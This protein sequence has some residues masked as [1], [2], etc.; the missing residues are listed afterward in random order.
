MGGVGVM[1]CLCLV[2]YENGYG[3]VLNEFMIME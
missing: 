3:Y 2:G 1:W